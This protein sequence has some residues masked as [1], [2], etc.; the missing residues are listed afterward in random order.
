MKHMNEASFEAELRDVFLA[1]AEEIIEDAEKALMEIEENPDN[2]QK[3]NLIFR[4]IHT[5]KG[6]ALV[7]GFKQLGE[8]AHKFETVLGKI[9]DRK[10]DM[11]PATMDVMLAGNDHF[12]TFVS[13]LRQNPQATIEG[14]TIEARLGLI[15]QESQVKLKDV[16]KSPPVGTPA[17][18][19]ARQA[20]AQPTVTAP[21]V[22][23]KE[24]ARIAKSP[25]S[26][27]GVKVLVCDDE[28][29]ILELIGEILVGAGYTPV[30]CSGAIEG[31]QVLKNEK[32]DIV[33]TDYQMPQMTGI[34]FVRK[35][36]DFNQFMPI[37]V[38]SGH[39]SREHFKTYLEIGVD[40]FLDK[41]F[42]IDALLIALRRAEK[43]KAMNEAVIDL[44]RLT[45][46][47][48]VSLEKMDHLLSTSDQSLLVNE[49]SNFSAILSE[50]R[51]RT[52]K[53]LSAERNVKCRET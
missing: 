8:F 40:E 49:R 11:T 27:R 7:A 10:I 16:E 18:P 9:R 47:A 21:E 2:F 22:R 43:D 4:L 20:E 41:P 25:P 5:I 15:D 34:D 50:M 39:S 6:S 29:Y 17:L 33:I 13:A 35:I 26:P 45:F 44:S 51:L 36:R 30:C 31:L 42:S 12:K 24:S 3:I 14:E 37:I 32:V 52:S 38:I 28:P 48:Y 46:K 23:A 53:L 19:I 1:E